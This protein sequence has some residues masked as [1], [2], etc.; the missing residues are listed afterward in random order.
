M[1]NYLI[2]TDNYEIKGTFTKKENW[3]KSTTKTDN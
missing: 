2:S 3:T 1:P